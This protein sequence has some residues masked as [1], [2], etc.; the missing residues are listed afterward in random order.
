[1]LDWAQREWAQSVLSYS[2]PTSTRTRQLIVLYCAHW[3]TDHTVIVLC[4][5][6]PLVWNPKWSECNVEK[7]AQTET[8]VQVPQCHQAVLQKG[9]RCHR[10]VWCDGRAVLPQRS[11]VDGQCQSKPS[12][13]Y[14]PPTFLFFF[15]VSKQLVWMKAYANG[16]H[17]AFALSF[18]NLLCG[19]IFF[20]WK[21]AISCAVD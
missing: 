10:H 16:G 17:I 2:M 12:L 7:V 11:S 18:H 9:W 13:P 3:H 4:P 6:A 19:V 15:C 21:L 14:P 1:M 5:A 8:C 20:S